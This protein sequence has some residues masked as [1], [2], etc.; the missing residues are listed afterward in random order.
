MNWIDGVL[1]DVA[2]LPDRNSPAEWPEAMLV[3]A[4]ELRQILEAHWPAP[5][6]PVN[7]RLLE[8]VTKL[9]SWIDD[10]AET[11]DPY[12]AAIEKLAEDAIAEAEKAKPLRLTD[13]EINAVHE[14]CETS[15]VPGSLVAFETFFAWGVQAALLRKLGINDR[16]AG[17]GA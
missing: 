2:E 9:L 5:S 12:F 16:P 3:T 15:Y 10:Y 4:Q 1:R 7:A 8:A 14:D 13:E 6:M 11:S 17:G